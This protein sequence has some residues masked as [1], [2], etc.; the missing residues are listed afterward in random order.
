MITLWHR[1]MEEVDGPWGKVMFVIVGGIVRVTIHVLNCVNGYKYLVA[2]A[3][4]I[5]MLDFAIKNPAFFIP[6]LFTESTGTWHYLLKVSA[7]TTIC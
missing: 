1:C 5:Y 6:A 4:M 2:R 3:F 7:L